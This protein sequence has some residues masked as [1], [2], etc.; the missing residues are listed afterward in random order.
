MGFT[1]CH[2]PST[3]VGMTGFLVGWIDW[4]QARRSKKETA[5]PSTAHF[6]RGRAN[7]SGPFEAQDK[8]DDRFL[9]VGWLGGKTRW[10]RNF[11]T[12][13]LVVGGI[14]FPGLTAW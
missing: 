3:A 14:E 2:D 9:V 10:A 5:D 11:A 13:G 12:T 6:A 8:R 4:C 1:C 7:C